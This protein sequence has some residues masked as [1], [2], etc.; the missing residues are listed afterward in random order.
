MRDAEVR[1]VLKQSLAVRYGAET[2]TIIVEELGLCR[3]SVR[4]DVAVIN[5]MIKGFEIKSDK[6]TLERLATQADF[7]GRVF[8]TATLVVAEKHLKKAM[9]I[10]PFWWGIETVTADGT[11]TELRE[12]RQ[13]PSIDAAA[14]SLLLWREEAASVLSHAG[15][16]VREDESR[17]ELCRRLAS[18]LALD[19]LRSAVRTALKNRSDERFRSQ[20]LLDGAMF[21]P[22]SMS[23]GCPSQLVRPRSRRYTYRPN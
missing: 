21:Q 22:S 11:L 20:R 10:L 16:P 14:V 4:A 19:D 2:D 12:C 8:D 6:D 15:A 7:Y 5:G 23:S 1:R 18:T 3:G 17:P 13:N 9:L